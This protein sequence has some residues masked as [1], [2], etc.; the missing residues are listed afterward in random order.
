[1]KQEYRSK[2]GPPF[3]ISA[4]DSLLLMHFLDNVFPLQYPMYRPQMWDGGRG[5]LLGLLLR[6]PAFYHAALAL[7]AYHR[8]DALPTEISHPHQIVFRVQQ[9]Q[10][11]EISIKTVNHS[12]QNSCQNSGLGILASVIQL[13]FFEVFP[14]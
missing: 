12:S 6:T 1:M 5:W 3:F 8:R 14:R 11:L 7:S 13:M 4:D 9:E 2:I 10:H